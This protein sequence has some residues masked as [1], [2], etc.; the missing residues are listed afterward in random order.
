MPGPQTQHKVLLTYGSGAR[1]G[2]HSVRYAPCRA[3]RI[4]PRGTSV[5]ASSV[6][7]STRPVAVRVQAGLSGRVEVKLRAIDRPRRQR[8]CVGSLLRLALRLLCVAAALLGALLA[9]D[10][11]VHVQREPPRGGAPVWP[12]VSRLVAQRSEVWRAVG[13]ELVQEAHRRRRVAAHRACREAVPAVCRERCPAR[14]LEWSEARVEPRADAFAA[15]HG[16]RCAAP[17]RTR[18]RALTLSR[19]QVGGGAGLAA[20]A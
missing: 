3:P 9:Y 7:T 18:T 2:A 14:W 10:V 6:A 8:S 11:G 15:E 5:M 20:S 4:A 16:P 1:T 17:A 13:H 12:Y 19:A